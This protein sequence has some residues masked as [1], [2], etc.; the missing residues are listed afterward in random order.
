M[1]VDAAAGVSE[2]FA[3]RREDP[4]LLKGEGRYT[5]DWNF[6]GQLYA[7]VLRSDRAHAELRAINVQVAR[8]APGVVAVFTGADVQHYKTPP[9][10]LKVPGRGGMQLKVPERPILARDRVRYVGQEIAMVVAASAAAAQDALELIEVEYF[11]RVAVVDGAVALE[12]GSPQLHE[13]VPGNL[14]FDF[15]Y[16]DEAAAAAA[17]TSAAH[18]TRLTLDSTRVSGNPMEPKACLVVY[19]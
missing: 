13:S 7:A 14:A 4:R 18:V 15:D 5:A 2:G 12:E 1:A 6:P 11:D 10:Q 9:P 3:G 19:Q 16:G 8:T 17:I